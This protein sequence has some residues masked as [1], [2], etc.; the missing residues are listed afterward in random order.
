[1][2]SR[3]KLERARRKAQKASEY[4]ARIEERAGQNGHHDYGA[5]VV[6]N[7]YEIAAPPPTLDIHEPSTHLP[8][9][10]RT[11]PPPPPTAAASAHLATAPPAP[12]RRG[13]RAV[14][15]IVVL[16][17]LGGGATGGWLWYQSRSDETASGNSVGTAHLEDVA[18]LGSAVVL[19]NGDVH[20]ED[21][22]DQSGLSSAIRR[23]EGIISVR[24]PV[25]VE[26]TARLVIRDRE[27]RLL[28]DAQG[29]AVLDVRGG[30]LDVSDSTLTS[31]DDVAGGPD[32]NEKDGRASVLV[33]GGGSATL[34]RAQV[35]SLG[36]EEADRHGFTISG[37][38][39]SASV[40]DTT[41]TGSHTGI[42]VTG[43]VDVTIDRA[44][45]S[46]SAFIGIELAGTTGVK[47]RESVVESTK[48]DAI[49]VRG[50]S[51]NI[52]LRGNDVSANAGS[53]LA[54]LGSGGRV[55]VSANVSHRNERA[56][57][58]IS[59][60]RDVRVSNN[61][62]WDNEVGVSLVGGNSGTTIEKNAISGNR[63]AGVESTSAGNTALVRGNVID[64]NEN[65]VVVSDGTVD[66]IDNQIEVNTFGIAVFDKSPKVQIRSN[67]I[68]KS[69]DGAIRF[70]K[71]D[72][73]V[74]Q[75]NALNSNR[76]APFVVDHAD[77]SLKFQSANSIQSGR[78]GN[79]W[80][81]EPLRSISE[82]ADLTPVPAEF[83]TQPNVEFLLPPSQTTR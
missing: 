71:A 70:L 5:A 68:I 18:G 10:S 6:E 63:T 55:D 59:N 2:T 75:G 50:V 45:V 8:P 29:E 74:I 3:R 38:G 80:V 57:I 77:D 35:I 20:I 16:A 22:A 7:P 52:E 39:T 33:N 56:G 54:I 34:Q 43:K 47:V 44:T 46:R 48:G 65:G 76:M 83:F 69:A 81:F 1:M 36:Q 32:A 27:V 28:S 31:W 58:L 12:R 14:L 79:E 72:G 26:S 25:V 64:H 11:A 24:L 53:G 23:T 66:I 19:R 78:K 42:T 61:K 62:V 17:V 13:L 41:F 73:I 37:S 21:L 40:T 60:T 49:A 82:L 15:I 30:T 67:T 9:M 4:L 51:S